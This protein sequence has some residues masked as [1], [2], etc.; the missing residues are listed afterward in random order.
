VNA[1]TPSVWTIGNLLTW[2]EQFF[3]DHHIGNPRLDAQ[4]LLA[5]ALTCRRPDLYVRF[6]SE[7]NSEQRGRFRELVKARA[8]GIPVAYLV[9]TKEFYLLEFEV[10]PAVLIPRPATETLVMAALDTLRPLTGPHVLDIGTG[11]GCVAIAI[12]VHNKAVKLTASDIS[13]AAIAIARRNARKH[14][15]QDRIDFIECDLFDALR[16]ERK[17]DLIVSNPPYI[18]TADL[19]G[20]M[21]DVKDH[22]PRLALDAGVDGFVVIDR[23]VSQAMRFLKPSGLLM[24]EVGIGQADVAVAKLTNA[25]YANVTI[26]K[27]AD[28]IARIVSGKQ[29]RTI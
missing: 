6:E 14:G 22:E 8:T 28:G 12:V 10:S 5:H 4:V 1:S 18:P 29:P 3:R 11:S 21:K 20:L 26:L 24:F 17:Y 19:D 15:V 25:G 23:L 27:D 16:P 2:T 9:G 13:S 7:P